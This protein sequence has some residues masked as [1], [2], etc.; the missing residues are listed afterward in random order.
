MVFRALSAE[1][2]SAFRDPGYV[3]IVWTLRADPV[4]NAT[5]IFRTETRVVSTDP[6]ARAKFRRYWSCFSPGMALI[7]W[8]SLGPLKR[9]AERCARE[10]PA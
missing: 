8:G 5:S 9:E 6:E 10:V 2:F 7:R 3:K 1:A 4:D